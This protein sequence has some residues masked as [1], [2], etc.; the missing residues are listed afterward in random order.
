MSARDT[1]L[2]GM[3]G[4]RRTSEKRTVWGQQ[5]IDLFCL[6]KAHPL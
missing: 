2:V 3:S 5:E 1:G 6:L 4:V